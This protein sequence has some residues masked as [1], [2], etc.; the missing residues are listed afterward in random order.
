M[1]GFLSHSVDVESAYQEPDE[2][3][4]VSQ[5]HD[6]RSPSMDINRTPI[7]VYDPINTVLDPRSPSEGIDRTPI[8]YQLPQKFSN[9]YFF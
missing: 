7:T 2:Y 3:S 5:F 4:R 8:T 6:P 9:F 1:G